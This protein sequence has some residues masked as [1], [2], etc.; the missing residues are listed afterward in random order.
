MTNYVGEYIYNLMLTK[1]CL[2]E[3]TIHALLKVSVLPLAQLASSVDECQ[4]EMPHLALIMTIH[5]ITIISRMK[6][7]QR[8][9]FEFR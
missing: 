3:S 6:I 4:L 2:S 8:S 9:G 1:S 7:R 5:I